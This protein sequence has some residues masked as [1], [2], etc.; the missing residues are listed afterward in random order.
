MAKPLPQSDFFFTF[1][2]L[3]CSFSYV[4]DDTSALNF[5]WISS[6]EIRT[7]TQKVSHTID[8]GKQFVRVVVSM[9]RVCKYLCVHLQTV[10]LALY[11]VSFAQ[12]NCSCV[13]SQAEP[14]HLVSF[15]DSWSYICCFDGTL[16]FCTLSWILPVCQ[17]T[18]EIIIPPWVRVH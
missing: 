7:F 9:Y 12:F 5:S 6:S 1:Y 17:E 11:F 18:V 16:A 3:L 8:I 10:R 2:L 14:K 13:V 4:T 15:F